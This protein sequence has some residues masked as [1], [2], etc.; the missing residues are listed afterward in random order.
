[1]IGDKKFAMFDFMQT[2][3]LR[4]AADCIGGSSHEMETQKKPVHSNGVGYFPMW[5]VML[6]S[7]V[8]ILSQKPRK[9]QLLIFT[10]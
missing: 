8:N 9:Q 7:D 6:S 1:M 3:P 4:F 10:S 5:S 2:R